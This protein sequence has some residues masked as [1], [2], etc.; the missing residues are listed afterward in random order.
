MTD[1]KIEKHIIQVANGEQSSLKVLYDQFGRAVYSLSFAILRDSQLAEDS[2]QEVFLKIMSHA[3]TY[4]LGGNPKAWI[5]RITRNEAINVLQKRK[6]MIYTDFCMA[7]EQES[8]ELVDETVLEDTVC[9]RSSI[10]KALD[11]LEMTSRE[12]VIMHIHF[13]LKFREISEAMNIPLGTVTWKYQTAIKKL[14]E[15][16][17]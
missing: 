17:E 7:D 1:E 8:Y 9:Y 3:D 16:L 14:Q 13:G 12:I 2:S 11:M 6:N 4:R 15:S 10:N 5:M